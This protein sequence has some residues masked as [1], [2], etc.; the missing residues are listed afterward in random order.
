M[1][2]RLRSIFSK[3]R[4][5]SPSG[6]DKPPKKRQ[7]RFSFRSLRRP[8]APSP[9]SPL[10]TSEY[11]PAQSGPEIPQRPPITDSLFD[12]RDEDFRPRSDSENPMAS[13]V[14]GTL[15]DTT[16]EES[17]VRSDS[18]NPLASPVSGSPPD[19]TE[20]EYTV[21]SDSE[22]T[23]V[24]PFSRPPP[25]RTTSDIPQRSP[26]SG[27][28][29]VR[30][31]S[32]V[33]AVSPV[34]G[35]IPR[36]RQEESPILGL[37]GFPALT[38][39]SPDDSRM[40]VD[41]VNP[42]QSPNPDSPIP[43]IATASEST[44][45]L[46]LDSDLRSIYAPEVLCIGFSTLTLASLI[47]L[48]KLMKVSHII[49]IRASPVS[50]ANAQFNKEVLESSDE[51]TRAEIEYVWL[52]TAL[53]GRWE[54]MESVV[55]LNGEMHLPDL[56]NYAS[57]MLTPEFKA[58]LSEVK[59]LATVQAREGKRVVMMCEEE[60]FWRCHRRMIADSLVAEDWIVK[61]MGLTAGEY[62]RHVMSEIVRV[63]E[64]GVLVY[65]VPPLA[66]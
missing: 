31:H 50:G 25:G 29:P 51:L 5:S 3:D 55:I 22:I 38:I 46:P 54:H 59:Y 61:H 40:S 41:K 47:E 33:P 4:S 52:G 66:N 2:R 15:P 9:D 13:P 18:E 12:S 30:S 11:S 20:G 14:P 16:E 39:N 32:N 60:S 63:T 58:G 65:D 21:R 37:G 8:R 53:G 64:D 44:I 26:F 23:A 28:L 43:T 42:S 27:S 57:Y 34:P 17:P 10:P 45:R 19:A 1:K 56:L 24:S 35:S 6:E 48:L 62:E 49:D 7:R 36:A